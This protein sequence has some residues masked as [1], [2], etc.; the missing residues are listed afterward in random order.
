[1]TAGP[2]T[3]MGFR[4]HGFAATRSHVVV[5]PASMHANRVSEAVQERC[6]EAICVT[7]QSLLAP[8]DE[9][10]LRTMAAFL[11]HPNV[12]HAI[13]VALSPSD[14]GWQ[15]LSAEVARSGRASDVELV[16]LVEQGG[17]GLAIEHT[18]ESTIRALEKAGR[19]EREPIPVSE[20][21]LGTE[22]GGSDANS[23]LTANPV[24][25]RCADRV[26][27]AGGSVILAEMTELIGAEHE[28]ARRAADPKLG[29]RLEAAVHRW[30]SFALEF[31]ED[32][33]GAN[34]CHGN[35][36]GGITTIEEKS[37]GCV[38]KSGTSRVVDLVG[39][40]ERSQQRGLVVMDT[41]GDDLEQLIAMTAGGANV[42]VFT[43]GRGTPTASPTV[44][45]I[46]VA[47]TTAMA[48]R[49]GAMIDLDAG[50]ILDASESIDGVGDRLFQL[51]I[52]IASGRETA[53]ERLAQRDFALPV[54]GA[55]A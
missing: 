40:G 29:R 6:P 17:V 41:S 28:L 48:T 13:V 27:D 15:A 46:K 5:V 22:C 23:G 10:P 21:V 7:H 54:T 44:P 3:F 47:S 4:R 37:L 8:G 38:R 9:L 49:L 52:D 25:G 33:T 14:P 2:A 24:L 12:S 55:G 45:T 34:P 35:I 43:T 42:I 1:M 30:E 39:F 31:G 11:T 50:A 51:V 16:T 36:V 26:V 53:S 19:V 20:L 18:V 32:I